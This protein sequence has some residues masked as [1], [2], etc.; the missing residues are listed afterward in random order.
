MGR[1]LRL[2]LKRLV[3]PMDESLDAA[4]GA[5]NDG[6]RNHMRKRTCSTDM[7]MEIHLWFPGQQLR[8][9]RIPKLGSL[10]DNDH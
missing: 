7:P 5:L 3:L 1:D 10:E 9:R 8:L 4:N 6:N 2:K